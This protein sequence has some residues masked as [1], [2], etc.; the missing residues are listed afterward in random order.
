MSGRAGKLSDAIDRISI[1]TGQ[2][3]SWLTLAMVGATF[4]VVVLRYVF[5]VGVVWMQEFVTWMHAMVFMLGAAYTLQQDDHVRVDIFYREMSER[6]KALVNLAGVVIFVAP[7]A[8]FFVVESLDYVTTAWQVREV[9]RD[10]G[11]LPYP[12]VPLL[13]SA[14]LIMPAAVLLQGISMALRSVHT[15]RGPR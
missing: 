11:G 7:L 4:V 3:A 8:I 13:K 12:F 10:S 14:L 5:G 6:Q 2:W 9:S 1:A 15:L